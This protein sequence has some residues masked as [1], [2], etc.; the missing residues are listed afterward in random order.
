MK[1]T[2]YFVEDDEN[3]N[4]LIEATLINGGFNAYG[5]LDPEM[6][7]EVLKD[8]RPDLIV[9]DLMLPKISGFDV[10]KTLKE[11]PSYADIPVIILSALSSERDI[12]K[13]LDMGAND[14]IT[15]PFGLREFISRI[16]ANI[17]KIHVPVKKVIKI[18]DL[19]INIDEHKCFL[20]G[21][22]IDLTNIEFDLLN[23]LMHS[24]DVVVTR[25]KLLKDV[26]NFEE[27]CETRTLDMHI[28]SIRR[29]LANYSNE[30]YI[31]T[32]RGIGFVINGKTI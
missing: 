31:E 23:I 5:F 30:T 4:Q 10:L 13:G 11:T 20:G 28:K 17:T 32:I 8:S 9:L 7:F 21:H 29:K 19:I 1:Y 6:F 3:V 18:R 2:I 25:K 12:V 16:N 24:P 14:Y 22:L 27:D 26:W 15:K